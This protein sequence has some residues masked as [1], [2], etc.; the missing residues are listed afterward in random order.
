MNPDSVDRPTAV[1]SNSSGI[2]DVVLAHGLSSIRLRRLVCTAIGL[3]DD[4]MDLLGAITD[5]LRI[6]EGALDDPATTDIVRARPLR[7]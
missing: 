6:V 3:S 4:S 5:R 1:L 2:P 7:R